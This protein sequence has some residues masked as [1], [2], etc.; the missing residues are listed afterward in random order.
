MITEKRII[1]YH[2][3]L[4]LTTSD[5]HYW[6]IGW[7]AEQQPRLEHHRQEL[8]VVCARRKRNVILAKKRW[9]KYRNLRIHQITEISRIRIHQIHK[10]P[11]TLEILIYKI[12]KFWRIRI[13]QNKIP[14]TQQI[15]IHQIPKIL[16]IRIHPVRFSSL[17]RNDSVSIWSITHSRMKSSKLIR[18]KTKFIA[19][20]KSAKKCDGGTHLLISS[21]RSGASA[22]RR[23]G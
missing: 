7:S 9:G 5:G 13:H 8:F 16:R 19:A 1:E 2:I 20:M 12:S 21:G 23:S 14:K 6:L 15:W 18:P 10:N 22:C 4:L 17:L 3:C 11:K